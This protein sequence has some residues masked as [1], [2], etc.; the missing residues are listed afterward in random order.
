MNN[1]GI[2]VK[3]KVRQKVVEQKSLQDSV[4]RKY[5]FGQITIYCK[6]PLK[7]LILIII[8]IDKKNKKSFCLWQTSKNT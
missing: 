6:S 4:G 1:H 2:I 3:K 7:K 8:K 5:H